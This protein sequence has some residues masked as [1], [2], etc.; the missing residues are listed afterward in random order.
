MTNVKHVTKNL[1]GMED[2]LTKVGTTKQIRADKTYDI[3]GIDV[4]YA[5]SSIDELKELD[6]EKFT[7]AKVGEVEYR[8]DPAVPDG[9][10]PV[11]QGSWLL[12]PISGSYYVSTIEEAAT[13]DFYGIDTVVVADRNYATF[14]KSEETVPDSAKFI[15]ALGSTWV[16]KY[17]H[18][19]SYYGIT[20]HHDIREEL[21]HSVLTS[22]TVSVDKHYSLSD[23]VYLVD[24]TSIDLNNKTLTA[25]STAI[26]MFLGAKEDNQ[27]GGYL[28]TSN[29]IIKNG[30]LDR[31]GSANPNSS[32][33]IASF[34]HMSN[35]L[36]Q[37]VV[38]KS[39]KNDH[40]M[41]VAGCRNF[42]AL[43]CEFYDYIVGDRTNVEHIQI[44][45]TTTSTGT[46]AY[47]P[48]DDTPSVNVFVR[49]CSFGRAEDS[50]Y[51]ACAAGHHS[52]SNG[53]IIRN[54][55]FDSN[56]V[57][58][59]TLAGFR[60][61][62]L[63]FDLNITSNLFDE[64]TALVMHAGTTRSA[65]NIKFLR[66]TGRVSRTNS[67]IYT[68]F[69]RIDGDPNFKAQDIFIAYN[70][71][72]GFDGH[73]GDFARVESA[74]GVYIND[75]DA[76]VLGR[77]AT[78][79]DSSYIYIHNNRMNDFQGNCVLVDV[80]CYSISV[81]TNT[82]TEIVSDA[83]LFIRDS[84]QVAIK[85]N[86]LIT[87]SGTAIELSANTDFVDVSDNIIRDWANDEVAPGIFCTS[88]SSD[89][90]IYDNTFRTPNQ[91]SYSID[92]SSLATGV[93][94]Y[95]NSTK[96]GSSGHIKLETGGKLLLSSPDGTMF[97][98]T[99]ANNGTITAA[100]VDA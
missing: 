45:S 38:F 53:S 92:V 14:V 46:P 96:A 71:F 97:A 27:V 58:G 100:D 10:V 62:G 81:L 30:T 37:D 79:L 3:G 74:V 32:G 99:V 5:V 54:I 36:I 70:E 44:E 83:S 2:L 67:N 64:C 86:N 28:A 13:K 52:E 9:D 23:Y 76:G 42:T 24:N 34:Y 35:V 39:V 60:A 95:S 61:I 18:D 7:Y 93:N 26:R 29:V 51:A 69:V 55:V 4:P 20:E 15:D 6:T 77:A 48:Y 68:D 87:M 75:N 82:F 43:S 49:E 31:N 47:G 22:S 78:V 57:Y 56:Y 19:L 85:G 91:A 89:T 41:E 40:A 66:N 84:Q 90:N 88:G 72:S 98:I 12:V 8:Y 33:P 80:G 65:K 50:G 11:L 25:A 1:V 73:R 17:T 16:L 21:Q 59:A 63:M 94:A